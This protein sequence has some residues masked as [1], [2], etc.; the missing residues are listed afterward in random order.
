MES[1][2]FGNPRATFDTY[3]KGTRGLDDFRWLVLWPLDMSPK[4][5]LYLNP[6][7]P[8]P[9]PTACVCWLVAALNGA[10]WVAVRRNTP[11]HLVLKG[12]CYWCGCQFMAW[13]D[14]FACV[15]IWFCR[16]NREK[17]EA[18][19][20]EILTPKF[21]HL[22]TRSVF[23]FFWQTTRCIHLRNAVLR[24]LFSLVRFSSKLCKRSTSSWMGSRPSCQTITITVFFM[25]FFFFLAGSETHSEWGAR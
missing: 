22:E 1:R 14:I 23:F 21:F 25:F 4:P 16:L 19:S 13:L 7:P 8:P 12:S 18:V 11:A 15:Y 5:L 20:S 10:E 24:H 3:T 9:T 6:P 2:G 17:N